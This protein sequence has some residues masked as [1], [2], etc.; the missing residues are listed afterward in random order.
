MTAYYSGGDSGDLSSTN[1]HFDIRLA[2]S[3]NGLDFTDLGPVVHYDDPAVYQ[4]GDELFPV[5]TFTEDDAWYVYYQGGSEQNILSYATGA[6]R[7]SLALTGPVQQPD[8][9]TIRVWGSL[10]RIRL[11]EGTVAIFTRSKKPST[12]E[13]RTAKPDTPSRVSFPVETYPFAKN[14]VFYLDKRRKTWFMYYNDWRALFVRLAPY[15]APDASPPGPPGDLAAIAQGAGEVRLTWTDAVDPDTGILEYKIYREGKL[16]GK[17]RRTGYLDTG[18]RE[19]SRHSYRVSATNLH[20]AE[21]AA[22]GATATTLPDTTAPGIVGVHSGGDPTRVKIDFDEQLDAS[23]AGSPRNYVISGGVSVISA[24]LQPDGRSVVLITTPHVV[25]GQ[26]AVT[27]VS[28]ADRAGKANVGGGTAAYSYSIAAGLIG[29]SGASTR[30]RRAL[31]MTVRAAGTMPSCWVM[32]NRS[33][34]SCT[35]GSGLAAGAAMPRSSTR[36][37]WSKPSRVV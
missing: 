32:F 28:I 11:D 15:G 18:L 23:S 25:D 26:Y 12:I 27:A 21:G 17:T 22:S 30:T 10:S 5:A 31:Q 19:K 14:S 29:Y 35:Q 37:G 4:S 33:Q 1:V 16:V 34:V 36:P 8:G 13:I 9:S 7:N 3:G 2:T 6:G 24:D 20:G